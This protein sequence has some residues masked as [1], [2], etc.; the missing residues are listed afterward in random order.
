MRII[1]LALIL[2]VSPVLLFA[3]DM[4]AYVIASNVSAKDTVV[5]L[6]V[7]MEMDGKRIVL[8]W[9]KTSGPTGYAPFQARGGTHLYEMRNIAAWQGAIKHLAVNKQA[10]K[11]RV[12][13]PTIADET[14]LFLS[15]DSFQPST[16]NSVSPHTLFGF[17]WTTVLL[18]VFVATV[19]VLAAIKRKPLAHALLLGFVLSW[20]LS[21]LRIAADHGMIVRTQERHPFV[22]PPYEDAK[23]FG[24]AADGIITDKWTRGF[25]GEGENFVWYRLAEHPFVPNQSATP[26]TF[27]VATEGPASEVLLQRG[28]FR[29]FKKK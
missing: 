9:E 26:E 8:A 27:W 21:D 13:V 17:A 14:D 10:I 5:E 3:E 22:M 25:S 12:R 11:G 18:V 29:L 4:T 24:D 20:A 19:F 16:I 6:D 28:T 2:V 1:V 23:S 7:P 15:P